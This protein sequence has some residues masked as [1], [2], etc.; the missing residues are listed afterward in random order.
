[1]HL[2]CLLS[3]GNTISIVYCQQGK[4]SS[5][6]FR[7][8]IRHAKQSSIVNH[9]YLYQYHKAEQHRQSR[10]R[11]SRQAG[12]AEQHRSTQAPRQDGGQAGS[13]PWRIYS[14]TTTAP[15]CID[16]RMHRSRSPPTSTGAARGGAPPGLTGATK[17]GAPPAST[18]HRRSHGA[19][20]C[21]CGIEAEHLWPLQ[22]G[23]LLC[24]CACGL[25]PERR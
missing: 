16:A 20:I 12:R 1:M 18:T 17:G 23:A 22:R 2:H 7:S 11:K 21:A 6:L 13:R 10:Q 15:Q 19:R 3:A 4:K 25:G 14:R 8:Q 9:S 24:I 5:V